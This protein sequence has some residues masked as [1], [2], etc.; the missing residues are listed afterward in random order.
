MDLYL[1][2]GPFGLQ[3]DMEKD[4]DGNNLLDLSTD[5]VAIWQV[6]RQHSY[7]V[8]HRFVGLD[9]GTISPVNNL[10]EIMKQLSFILLTKKK[11]N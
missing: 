6:S 10:L 3:K 4:E 11:T 9:L 7:V 8:S 1:V 5:H 2:H